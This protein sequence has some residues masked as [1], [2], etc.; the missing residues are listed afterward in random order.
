[1]AWVCGCG[2]Q[3]WAERL[4]CRACGAVA[5]TS[6]DA[7]GG[8]TVPQRLRRALPEFVLLDIFRVANY[9]VRAAGVPPEVAAAAWRLRTWCT[10][11]RE[12][13]ARAL[14]VALCPTQTQ[15]R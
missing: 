1:M 6:N 15:G 11:A 10:E 8:V 7:A 2:V 9:V 12:G 3:N 5:P 4:Q 13:D 14:Y